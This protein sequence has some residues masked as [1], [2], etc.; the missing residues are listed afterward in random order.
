MKKAIILFTG[1]IFLL[2]SACTEKVDSEAETREVKNEGNDYVNQLSLN[3][4][5]LINNKLHIWHVNAYLRQKVFEEFAN[6]SSLK[7]IDNQWN[8]AKLRVASRTFTNSEVKN[9]WL[10]SII[11]DQI[12]NYGIKNTTELMK[13]FYE[14]CT[15]PEYISEIKELFDKNVALRKGHAIKTYKTIDGFSLDARVFLPPDFKKGDKR[16]AI[17]FFH[18]GS[19]Y[20]GKVE[21]TFG[22]CKSYASRG[23]V[24]IGVEYRL[25]DRHGVTPLECIADAKSIIRWMRENAEELGID[26]DRIVSCGFSSGGHIAACAGILKILEE[27]LEDLSISS[28]PNAMVFYY[29]CF[30]PTLDRWFVKQVK[31]RFPPEAVSPNHNIRPGLPPSLVL[32]GTEDRNCPFETAKVFSQRMTEAVNRCELHTLEGAGHVF[33]FDEKYS[34]EASKAMNDFLASLGYLPG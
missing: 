22:A 17:V 2:F 9:Y 7:H 30:D 8:T 20:Q 6:D 14:N 25:Y 29:S 26:P 5:D 3:D 10:H 1:A 12:D 16:P 19:W 4:P 31:N 27:P 28:V 34:K 15:N 21:W 18:G 13:M 24:A 11:Y 32:H 23:M 33:V